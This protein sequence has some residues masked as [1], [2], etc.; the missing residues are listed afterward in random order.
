M[1]I[2]HP[3]DIKIRITSIKDS[4][5]NILTPNDIFLIFLIRD[6]FDNEYVAIHDPSGVETKNTKVEDGVLYVAIENYKLR[7]EISWKIGTKIQ[8]EVFPDGYWQWFD[9]YQ[10][11]GINIKYI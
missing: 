11:M 7:G 10:N 9:K 5:G 2:I 3:S 6:K 8:D 4:E 1:D